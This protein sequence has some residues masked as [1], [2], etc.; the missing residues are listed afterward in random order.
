M[1]SR[2]QIAKKNIIWA[3]I[4]QI[5]VIILP[6]ITRTIMIYT[7]GSE[8][9][10]L[11]SL[12]TSIL[13]VLNVA[14]LGIGNAVVYAMYKPLALNDNK[15]ICALLGF[16]RKIYHI[17]GLVVVIGG[18]AILPFIRYL[19]SGNIPDDVNV[20]I[21]FLI[22]LLDT[23]GSYF[24]FSY[25]A[26]ILKANQRNEII[27]KV[28]AGISIIKSVGQILV[29][30][31]CKN[32]YLY[33]L[34]VP[35]ASIL[36]NI[37]VACVTRKIYPNY[38]CK[39]KIDQRLK[40]EIKKKV[41]ALFVS[42]T[43]GIIYNSSDSIA[44]SAFLGLITLTKYNNY[45]YI[46]NA[47]SAVV[48]SIFSS[49]TSTIGN[50]IVLESEEKNYKD[51]INLSF[52]NSWIVGWCTVCLFCLYQSFMKIWIGEQLMFDEGIIIGF[53]LYF[54]VQQLKTVLNVYRDAAGLWRE[55]MWRDCIANIFDIVANIILVQIIGVYGI[56]ISTII[57]ILFISYPWQA[58]TVHK[59][60][61]HCSMWPYIGKLGFYSF[62]TIGACWFT[63]Y[64]CNYI[65]GDGVGQLFIKAFICC[66]IPNV[67]FLIC[68][69]KTKEFSNMIGVVRNAFKKETFRI[70]K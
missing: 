28:S 63:N 37:I 35:L 3:I 12:F 2:I 61:F 25:Q 66:T 46:L 20:Y 16:Y 62:V 7:W 65:R 5:T 38:S 39:G 24:L 53:C 30:L 47:V 41:M 9:L 10:G 40:T 44:I 67:I 36:V 57:A 23:S 19:I 34:F 52:I 60:L 45:Y 4:Y 59:N 22:Y 31:L 33:A 8:Y 21:L 32:Y 51:Y 49:I 56:L 68:Y 26:A 15:T 42:K 58:W 18:L 14:E 54:Y 27:N 64:I 70:L 17:I 43:T 55:D 6:F 48:S 11:N 1:E 13:S 50:S 69:F 29:L